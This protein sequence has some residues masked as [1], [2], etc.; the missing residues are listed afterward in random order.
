MTCSRCGSDAPPHA[1]FCPACGEPL[2]PAGVV[3]ERKTVSVLFVDI[4]GST[5]RADEADP[6]DVRE[7]NQ[8]YYGEVSARIERFGGAIEKYV[9]DAVM[10]VFGAPIAHS[11]DA[12]RAV[13][14]SL[15][16][17]E[18]VDELNE[19]HPNLELQVRAAVCTGEA[20]VALDAAPADA[21]A[22]GDV[23]NTAA[24]LQS[25]AP[26]GGAVVGAETY[27][28]TRHAF[29][30]AALDDIKAKG[31]RDPVQAWLVGEPIVS[32]SERPTSVTPMV[33]REREVLLI[34]TVWERAV[35][36]RSPHLVSLI[37][38]A[39]IGKSRLAQ[40]VSTE[41]QR[42]AGRALVGRSLPYEEQSPYRAFGQ[43]LRHAAG[44]YEN[45]GAEDARRK[46]KV[47]VDGLFPPSEATETVRYLSL[48]LG[49]GAGESVS[50]PIHLLF[51]AR[52][53]VE[54]LAEDEPLLL[55]FEDVHWADD[56]LL[57]LVDYLV[58]HVH[59]H[60]VLFL[61]LARPEFLETRASWGS[62]RIGQTTLPLEP[63]TS[64]ES[65]EVVT[66]LAS[67]TDTATISKV[68]ER[69]EGNPLFLE[70]LAATLADADVGGE[71]PGTV[72][73]A[74]AARIDALPSDARTA[75]LHASVVGPVFWRGVVEGIGN[76]GDVDG[77]LEALEAR[78]LV[79]RSSNSQVHGDAEFAFKH[80]LIRDV[81]YG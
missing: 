53:V 57:D 25:A 76:L 41:I 71:L 2:S 17:L 44:I 58:T 54:L 22:T 10:A 31:K 81:A 26:P 52:R 61:A 30:Y 39:G 66:W 9:G 29:S 48:V 74:I 24:R 64:E 34:R 69:A 35:S 63:L 40:E 67:G 36:A 72:R 55:V 50:E 8:L 43:I 21:L 7:L 47:F 80:A 65:A 70:E 32:P 28:L 16:V 45:D 27:R 60:P 11:D 20:M 78:G 37:G 15:S 4:V 77:S 1:R 59:D 75:L 13:R 19:R 73:A 46:L 5:E 38:P 14:A 33:G 12:E 42:D 23:V 79:R 51:A 49:L 3:E 56:A 68:V 6:E 62:G 18:G